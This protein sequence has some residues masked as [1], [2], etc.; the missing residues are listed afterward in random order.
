[1]HTHRKLTSTLASFTVIFSLIFSRFQPTLASAQTGDG[2]NRQVNPES[3]RVSFIGPESGRALSAFRALGTFLRP[4]DPAMALVKRF[5]PEFG[6]SNPEHEL[7]EIRTSHPE[8]GRVIVRYQ[9]E[10]QGIPVMGGELIV[11]TNQNGDLYS[12]NGEVSPDLTLQ[13]QPQVRS[14]LRR[15]LSPGYEG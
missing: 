4:Q 2:I 13:T 3:G 10:Y 6:L 9:Q 15:S 12:M 8:D 11:N 1:M 7:S 14:M 5:G